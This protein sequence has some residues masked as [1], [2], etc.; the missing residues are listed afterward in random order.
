MAA[1]DRRSK[2][3][4]TDAD[5]DVDGVRAYACQPTNFGCVRGNFD[6]SGGRLLGIVYTGTRA[7]LQCRSAGPVTVQE[8]HL[9]R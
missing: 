6:P 3:V 7:S 2:Y 1:I 9:C 4:Y 5:V 8:D